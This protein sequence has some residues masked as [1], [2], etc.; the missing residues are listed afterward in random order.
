MT[1]VFTEST[2]ED[3]ALQWFK[4]LGYAILHGPDIAPGE[5]Q[6]ERET[7]ADVVLVGRLRATL[8]RINP[9]IPQEAR[10]ESIRKLLRTEHPSLIQNNHRFHR[11]VADGV[12]VEYQAKDRTVH[13]QV[14][15]FDF[16]DLEKND[17]LVDVPVNS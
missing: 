6:A 14:W 2:V 12:P 7:Y 16:V 17:W 11:Y 5:L 13:D 3:A 4:G 8:K 10:E 1:S 15:L 9:K